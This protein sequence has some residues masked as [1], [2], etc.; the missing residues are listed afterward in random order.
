MAHDRHVVVRADQD[1][2]VD[3]GSAS[4]QPTLQVV[5]VQVAGVR[6]AGELASGPVADG[7]CGDL[8]GGGQA[9]GPA[10]VHPVTGAVV[11]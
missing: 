1:H 7:E 11:Q 8:G 3:V 4:V 9:A 6:A 2:I 10:Q 5:G